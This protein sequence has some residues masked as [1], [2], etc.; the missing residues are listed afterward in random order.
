MKSLYTLQG[1]CLHQGQLY[2]LTATVKSR[3]TPHLVDFKISTVHSTPPS[4]MSSRYERTN[5]YCPLSEKEECKETGA[6]WDPT[7]KTWYVLIDLET[8]TSSRTGQPLIAFKKWLKPRTNTKIS[9]FKKQSS[10]SRIISGKDT[11][12]PFE[13]TKEVHKHKGPRET[14]T[15]MNST[16][17]DSSSDT[18][19]FTT[20]NKMRSLERKIT[21]SSSRH[22][23]VNSADSSSS[24]SNDNIVYHDVPIKTTDSFSPKVVIPVERER[25]RALQVEQDS[26]GMEEDNYHVPKK[27]KIQSRERQPSIDSI[28]DFIAKDEMTA[29]ETS[30]LVEEISKLG[31]KCYGCIS[32][33]IDNICATVSCL[34]HLCPLHQEQCRICKKFYCDKHAK[35]K[36]HECGIVIKDKEKGI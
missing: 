12:L 29:D 17:S 32:C 34:K 11:E 19:T 30:A 31:K 24:I 18:S 10:H 35:T 22:K 15:K 16:I 1:N 2:H 3:S 5:L 28:D 13:A 21:N 8:E 33:D 26:A 36:S 9:P 27:S 25:K 23:K 7:A 20:D 14:Y 4:S 6:L